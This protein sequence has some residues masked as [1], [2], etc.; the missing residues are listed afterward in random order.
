MRSE[1]FDFLNFEILNFEVLSFES[2]MV[3]FYIEVLEKTI[4]FH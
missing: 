4:N 1:N 3:E 2:E